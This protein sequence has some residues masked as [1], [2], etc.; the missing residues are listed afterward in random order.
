MLW[1]VQDPYL[2]W[3]LD[4]AAA[5]AGSKHEAETPDETPVLVSNGLP[6]TRIADHPGLITGPLPFIGPRPPLD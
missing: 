4:E 2:A 6:N 1:N 5:I 3:C